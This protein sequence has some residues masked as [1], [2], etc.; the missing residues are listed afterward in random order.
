MGLAQGDSR[1]GDI[2]F[3]GFP[4]TNGYNG[5]ASY[6]VAYGTS[7]GDVMLNTSW[8]TFAYLYSLVLHE[9]GHALG[10]DH[11]ALY[12]AVMFTTAGQNGLTPDDIAGIQAIY[13]AGSSNNSPPFVSINNVTLTEGDTGTKL[14]NFT[15]SLSAASMST[16]TVPFSTSTGTAASSDFVATS[17]SLTFAPWQTQGTIAITING[18]TIVEPSETFVVNLGNPTGAVLGTG[19]GQG[20]IQNDDVGPSD[21]TPPVVV[22]LSPADGATLTENAAVSVSTRVTDNV[23]VSK[24]ELLWTNGGTN[25]VVDCAS[26]QLPFSCV[27]NGST[28]TWSFTPG[29]AGPRTWSIRA[30]DAANVT[31]SPARALNI[32]TGSPSLP[33][34]AVGDA[35]QT[36]GDSGTKLFN[37]TV[38]LSAASTSAVTVPFRTSTGTATA[39]SD[40]VATSG[41]LT[42][43][44]GE[45]LKSIAITVNGDT[46]SE[47]DETFFVNL[48]SPTGAVLGTGQGRGTIT[49]DDGG[50]SDTT[51]PVV[52]QLSPAD[53]AT[54]TENSAISVS[55]RVTDNVAVSKA[56]L[57]WTNGSTNWTVDCAQPQSPFLCVQNGSTYTW[58]F[59]VGGAGERTWSVRA[60]DAANVT[61]SPTRALNI[62]TASPSL[63]AITVGDA[64]QTEGDSGTELFNFTVTLS[65]A[66]TGTVTVPFSTS[67]GTATAGSDYVATTGTLTFAPGE[68]QKTVAIT[69]NGD[70]A[71][72][73]DETFFVN[74][75]VPT[76]AVLGTSQGQG[77]I[78][79]DD[80]GAPGPSTGGPEVEALELL[81]STRGAIT[82]IVLTFG[83]PGAPGLSQN[84]MEQLAHYTVA[85]PGRDR[86]FGTRDDRAVSLGSAVYDPDRMTMTLTPTKP[87]RPNQ[88]FQ[89][90]VNFAAGGADLAGNRRAP[91][92]DGADNEFTVIVGRGTRLSYIDSDGDVVSL[93]LARGGVMEL[94][95]DPG[96]QTRRLR[97]L[98]TVTDKSV[99]SGSLRHARLTGDGTAHLESVSG[100]AGVQNNLVRPGSPFVLG[101]IS[102]AIDALLESEEFRGPPPPR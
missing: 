8:G 60:S 27:Q 86:R 67:T 1:F 55:A 89:I 77:T 11:S 49:N 33:A 101:N 70:T 84:E 46:A 74:L 14:F 40:Y 51:P 53:G 31:T 7:G 96:D 73:P 99:L 100:L 39:G 22:Q 72:E 88:L 16:V 47:P 85:T 32:G 56:E 71:S 20:T 62:G 87:Q 65:M 82:G 19:Q 17:G 44:P 26:P 41:T 75:A 63:P 5:Y 13:G 15:L 18:D 61:T 24:A 50:S 35:S 90:T 29:G 76:G 93:V 98:E 37:F 81:T 25:W 6:P 54:L 57:L 34:I 9:T 91:S 38:T 30:S 28:Y 64:S 59:T 3:G 48:G 80:P 69:V 95:I 42:F 52:V 2:R 97:L 79:N 68:T 78:T 66:S 4:M 83:D 94:T 21:T 36:E 45:T 58:S 23:A 102:A 92:G 43:A 10:L 12:G